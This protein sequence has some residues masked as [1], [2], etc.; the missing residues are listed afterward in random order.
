MTVEI[1]GMVQTQDVSESRGD[2][3]GPGD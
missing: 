1:I 2:A 3:G